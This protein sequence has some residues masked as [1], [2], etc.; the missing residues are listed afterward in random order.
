MTRRK[1]KPKTQQR[2]YIL[3]DPRDSRVRYVGCTKKPIE[4]R[5]TDHLNEAR[6]KDNRPK[7]VWLRELLASGL[8]PIGVVLEEGFHG[9][10]FD[11]AV[12]TRLLL[13]L[14]APLTNVHNATIYHSVSWVDLYYFSRLSAQLQYTR[15][16]HLLADIPDHL[17]WNEKPPV[18]FM[19]AR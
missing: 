18:K 10:T 4:Q 15:W 14:G 7:N 3:V 6:M 13:E 5:V 12:W 9:N 16:G 19:S 8:K 11:E 17:P 2:V 1:P